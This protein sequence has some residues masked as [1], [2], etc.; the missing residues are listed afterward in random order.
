MK[1]RL[2]KGIAIVFG[3]IV[4]LAALPLSVQAADNQPP[5]VTGLSLDKTN[6]SPG[7]TITFTC[8]VSDAS[9]VAEVV[10]YMKNN[11][12]YTDAIVFSKKSEGV[13]TASYKV[14][15][16]LVNGWYY[17]SYF[18][19]KDTAGNTYETYD[20]NVFP[21]IRFQV[22]GGTTDDD[23]PEVI[24]TFVS[25]ETVHPGDKVKITLQIQDSHELNMDNDYFYLY[26]KN[27][28]HLSLPFHFQKEGDM[29]YSSYQII[30]DTYVNG[31][32]VFEKLHIEDTVG[33][34]AEWSGASFF[35]KLKFHVE[36]ASGDIDD[37]VITG[38]SIDQTSATVGDTVN[39]TLTVNDE[40]DL[41]SG[42]LSTYMTFRNGSF[43][44]GL[45]YFTK[46]GDG[47]Y[48]ASIPITNSFVDGT[49]YFEYL[50]CT[51]VIGNYTVAGP[52]DYP[53]VKFRISGNPATG[54]YTKSGWYAA[55]DEWYY[56]DING[57][58]VTGW[59]KYKNKWYYMDASGAMQTGW[60][61][62]GSDWY[63][64]CADGIMMTGW[65]ISSGNWYYMDAK[66]RMTKGWQKV[67]TSWYYMDSEGIMQIGWV[68]VNGKWYCMDWEGRMMTGWAA[69]SGHWYFF[70]PDGAMHTGW[71]KNNNS[72][73]YMDSEGI[74]QTG[75]VKS[76]GS[77]FY[78]DTNGK[79]KTGWLA[80]GSGW[81][82]LQ[83]NG[84]M[85]TGWKSIG[86]K[87]Y[88]FKP[89]G[90]MAANEWYGGYWFSKSG[91]W[92]YKP[93]GSWKKDNAGWWFGDT[94][95]WYAKNQ[96]TKI[97]DHYYK[98]NARGYWEQ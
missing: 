64:I 51:D 43:Y 45:N 19:A 97:N 13:Y 6:V 26:L 50:K 83:A 28:E 4:L 85:V 11:D 57:K 39:V 63:Y 25:M 27:G 49:Y 33:N 87:W 81:Y 67:G 96:T 23:P 46:T 21:G 92:T 71:L 47:V 8:N 79:M 58:F 74:M 48:T 41:A 82:Y 20:P 36:G 72:W 3:L 88:Y 60:V 84:A 2:K 24:D 44:S 30:P 54:V 95:G 61:K 70:D 56:N 68:K 15:S 98:F 42:P 90:A 52:K 80:T 12:Y 16:T 34:L 35:P 18:A 38:L 76:G 14:P 86:G 78:L 59:L 73:Y 65:V 93:I 32:Y 40:N 10:L 29:L 55:N 17:L 89:T 91:A 75:W 69:G 31:D 66:G 9:G 5:K 62:D 1:R 94:S 53:Q 22:S 37:P 7:S 77:W